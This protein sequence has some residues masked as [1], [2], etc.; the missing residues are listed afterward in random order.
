MAKSK[1]KIWGVIAIILGIVIL[2]DEKYL[3]L[4][5]ALYLIISGILNLME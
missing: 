3:A 2:I 4:L 1:R 5:V